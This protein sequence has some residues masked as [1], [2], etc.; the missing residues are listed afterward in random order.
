[1]QE[2]RD[3]LSNPY[4]IDDPELGK[5]EVDFLSDAELQFWT[6]LLARYLYPID[7]NKEEQ[8][9]KFFFLYSQ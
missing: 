2:E 9:L 8:V 3:D 7:D 1:M 6:D 4:W 5:G